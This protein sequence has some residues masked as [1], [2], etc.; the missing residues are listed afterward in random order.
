MPDLRLVL[1]MVASMTATAGQAADQYAALRTNPFIVP[2]N[3]ADAQVNKTV[4]KHKT[5]NMKLRATVVAGS[6]SQAN[7]DG[8]IIGLG[9][10]V[11]GYQLAEVHAR[12]VVLEQNGT[13]KEILIDEGDESNRN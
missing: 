1:L 12:S 4:D 3:A 6:R 13:R 11:N 5:T 8:V 7:I 10:D 2:V 9:E